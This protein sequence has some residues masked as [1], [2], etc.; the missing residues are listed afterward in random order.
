MQQPLTNIGHVEGVPAV[1][2]NMPGSNFSLVVPKQTV[3]I[4]VRE[5]NNYATKVQQTYHQVDKNAIKLVLNANDLLCAGYIQRDH[6]AVWVRLLEDADR[7]GIT[8]HLRAIFLEGEE[9]KWWEK[10]GFALRT[11]IDIF[12]EEGLKLRGEKYLNDRLNEFDELN[13]ITKEVE[14][15]DKI[16]CAQRKERMKKMSA[17]SLDDV[18][19]TSSMPAPTRPKVIVRKKA[20]PVSTALFAKGKKTTLGGSKRAKKP[21]FRMGPV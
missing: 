1:G 4:V 19:S 14:E 6:N 18:G 10:T 5:Y 15:A 7:N 13:I 17:A 16:Y 12:V 20:Q 8:L 21:K 2:W 3:L 11:R 9:G